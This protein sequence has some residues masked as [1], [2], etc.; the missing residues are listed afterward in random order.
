LP[1]DDEV[2][3]TGVQD[4]CRETVGVVQRHR[5]DQGIAAIEPVAAEAMQAPGFKVLHVQ[6]IDFRSHCNT[7]KLCLTQ[8]REWSDAKTLFAFL[9]D[10]RFANG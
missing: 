1:G 2:E 7:F 5:L 3:G 4:R 6:D 10:E 8:I 9:F